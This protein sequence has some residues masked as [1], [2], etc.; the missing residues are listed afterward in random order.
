MGYV[1]HLNRPIL[2]G[3]D[4]FDPRT[5]GVIE[6]EKLRGH[7]NDRTPPETVGFLERHNSKVYVRANPDMPGS[8]LLNPWMEDL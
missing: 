8:F 6:S 4:K 5:W 7:L 3:L 2:L 1:A